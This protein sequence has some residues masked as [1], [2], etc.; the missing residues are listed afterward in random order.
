MNLKVAVRLYTILFSYR[1]GTLPLLW[2][3]TGGEGKEITL[4]TV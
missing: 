4:P 1:R 3:R 2:E